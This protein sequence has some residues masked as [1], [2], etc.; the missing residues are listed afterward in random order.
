MMKV[1]RGAAP[2]L[3]RIDGAGRSD[4][5]GRIA[6]AGSILAA[7]RKRGALGSV[8][9]AL[10]AG[11]HRIGGRVRLIPPPND[12]RRCALVLFELPIARLYPP[13]LMGVMKLGV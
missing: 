7:K 13:I 9:Q 10:I 12:H 5:P 4:A 11:Q 3:S 2:W 1:R 8:G 6:A